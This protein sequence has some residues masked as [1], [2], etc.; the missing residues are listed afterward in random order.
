MRITLSFVATIILLAAAAPRAAHGQAPSVSVREQQGVYHVAARF[1]V[2]ATPAA[3]L[4]VLTDYERIP[5]FLPDVK[6]SIVHARTA[7][8]AVVEQEAVSGVMLFS[9]RMHLVLE[10][11]EAADELAFRDTCGRSFVT[12]AG[13]WRF[14]VAAGRTIVDYELA[15]DPAFD[16]PS[17][18]ITRLLKKDS[19]EMIARIQKEVAR[20]ATLAAH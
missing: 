8:H 16:V 4:A 17:F 7:T 19:G 13:R 11:D 12:Y 6:T 10:I 15:A 5:T 2:A 9:K 3:V 18:M 20:R 1:E 14:A